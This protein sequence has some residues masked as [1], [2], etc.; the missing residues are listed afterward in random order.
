LLRAEPAPENRTRLVECCLG[1]ARQLFDSGSPHDA[2]VCLDVGLPH[3]G[4]EPATMLR[5]AEEFARCGE[6]KKALDLLQRMPEPRPANRVLLLAADAALLSG[7]PDV[8]PVAMRGDFERVRG[9]FAHLH[10][11]ADDAARDA[12]QG[13]SLASPFLEWKVLLRGLLAY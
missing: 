3:A 11:G 4:N 13:I 5:L 1:R 10:A 6:G 12:L 7:T 8:L 9:A 2:L